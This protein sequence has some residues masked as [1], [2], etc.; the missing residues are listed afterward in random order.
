MRGPADTGAEATPDALTAK[1]LKQ[2]GISAGSS[3]TR[4]CPARFSVISRS[5]TRNPASRV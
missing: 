4:N 3:W 2:Y 1:M 5:A